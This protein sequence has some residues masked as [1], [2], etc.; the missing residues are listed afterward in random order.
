MKL[1][2][3]KNWAF[4]LL[5]FCVFAVVF[6]LFDIIGDKNSLSHAVIDGLMHGI[7]MTGLWWIADQ[8]SE[9]IDKS[10]QEDKADRKHK[11]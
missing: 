10:I 9:S 11:E 1:L 2:K 8:A 6:F 4:Y 3:K 5:L 7:V